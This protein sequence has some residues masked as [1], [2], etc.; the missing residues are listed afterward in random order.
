MLF[1]FLPNNFEYYVVMSQGVFV[2]YSTVSDYVLTTKA[3]SRSN[4]NSLVYQ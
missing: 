2:F 4:I 1:L 3:L